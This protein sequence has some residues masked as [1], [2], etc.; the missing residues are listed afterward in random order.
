MIN[1][2]GIV[3]YDKKV[4]D[5]NISYI[6]KL[7]E[8][9]EEEL[10]KMLLEYPTIM[11]KLDTHFDRTQTFLKIYM[12]MPLEELRKFIKRFPLFLTSDSENVL[13]IL[14]LPNNLKWDKKEFYDFIIQ[15]PKVFLFKHTQ[16]INVISL[17]TQYKIKSSEVFEI[18]KKY[19]D[20]LIANRYSMLEKKLELFDLLKLR[21]STIRNLIKT[22]PFILLKS[23]NSFVNKVYYF[24][25][26]LGIHIEDIEIYPIIFVFNLNKD[27][28]PRC[29]LMKKY[30][31]WIPFKEVFSLTPEEFINRIGAK[32]EDY[33]E[34][35]SGPLH[36]RDIMFR[37]IPH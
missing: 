26:D 37:Y 31:K 19:P 9:N 16:I 32:K 3:K 30:N 22:Y 14:K 25:N 8:A 27:I 2:V 29:E 6:Q 13:P 23:Y 36:E 4:I 21:K 28:K 34:Y 33:V 7:T 20:L 15:N 24:K 5:E 17:I 10:R 12:D 18:L 11:T 35:E 1:L